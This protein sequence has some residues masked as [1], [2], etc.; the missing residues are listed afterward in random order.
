MSDAMKLCQKPLGNLRTSIRVKRHTPNSELR[1]RSKQEDFNIHQTKMQLH[2][3]KLKLK[4]GAERHYR[5]RLKHIGL[6]R[7]VTAYP[8]K[9]SKD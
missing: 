7:K 4:K 5:R 6:K 8:T 3:A 2:E 9:K 1:L